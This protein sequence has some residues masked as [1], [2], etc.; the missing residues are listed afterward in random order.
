MRLIIDTDTAGD[1]V[2][3]ILLA[4]RHPGVT[5]EALTICNGNIAFEQQIENALFTLEMAGRGGTVP[6]HA[7]CPLPMLRKP[8]DAAYVFGQDGMSGSNFPKARQ[9]PDQKHA[10]DAIVDLVMENP[11][12]ITILAQ[13]P[14][15]NIALAY[16]K[17]PGIAKAVRHRWIMGGTDNGIG[18]VTP[19]AEFNFYVD[20]EAAKIVMNA[21]FPVT[22]S[23][24]TLTLRSGILPAD[25]LAAIEGL[26]SPLADFFVKVNRSTVA[27]TEK[28]HGV[29]HSTHPDSLTC[30]C[31]IDESLILESA[32][33]VVDVEIA[34]ELTRAYC[35]VS[36]PILPDHDLAD[37]RLKPRGPNARVIKAADT[38]RF[39]E[40]LLDALR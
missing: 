11:G 2:F 15:T 1:D 25:A 23:T 34:G 37:P 32:D 27:W 19:A 10:V 6:V 40:M 33:C 20:P 30:A 38:A 9:R 28:K 17:E 8:V 12:E 3:S 31:M 21:G 35:S 4:L 16:L 14:L 29:S 39:G 5:L 18:N 7:G 24:W 22:L 13:A 26:K 36:S